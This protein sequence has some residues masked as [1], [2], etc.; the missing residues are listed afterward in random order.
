MTLL[1]GKFRYYATFCVH[2]KILQGM[3]FVG[4]IKRCFIK[5]LIT[6]LEIGITNLSQFCLLATAKESVKSLQSHV[7]NKSAVF[8]DLQCQSIFFHTNL[9]CLHELWNIFF[10]ESQG[11][12]KVRGLQN[13]VTSS[14]VSFR[15]PPYKGFC[16]KMML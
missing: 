5:R 11:A 6:L 2:G 8:R 15:E 7:K 10:F 9:L 14:F 13:S 3:K 12:E 4:E 1:N 16:E